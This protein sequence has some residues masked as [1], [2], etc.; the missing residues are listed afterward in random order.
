MSDIVSKPRGVICHKEFA[1]TLQQMFKHNFPYDP[2]F[3]ASGHENEVTFPDIGNTMFAIS[4][5]PMHNR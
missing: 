1:S 5:H 4:S 3:N 2:S